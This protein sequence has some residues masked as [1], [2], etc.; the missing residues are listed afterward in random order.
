MLHF[1]Q[2]TRPRGVCAV[3]AR[4]YMLIVP[5]TAL[6]T[7]GGKAVKCV[8]R[9]AACITSKGVFT[10]ESAPKTTVNTTNCQSY[11]QISNK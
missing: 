2:P 4:H 7:V 8:E 6:L 5:R 1:S 10:L 9:E 11:F 3:R